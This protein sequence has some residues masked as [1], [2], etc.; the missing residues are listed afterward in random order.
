MGKQLAPYPLQVL[1]NDYLI[2]GTADGDTLICMPKPDELG[3][4]IRLMN[5]RVQSTRTP[6][7]A[8]RT[9]AKYI[10]LYNQALAVIPQVDYTQLDYYGSWKQYKTEINGLFYLGP[11]WVTGRL[12]MLATLLTADFPIYDVRFGSLLP[13]SQWPGFT[14]P[15]AL[16]NTVHLIG[17]ES[18]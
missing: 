13:G 4:T 12:T 7:A 17:W 6:P 8:V 16:L 15:F 3:M 10:C 18:A 11:Y 14:A 5:A 2:D 9:C 1:T